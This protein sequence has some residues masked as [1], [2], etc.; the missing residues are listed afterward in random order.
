MNNFSSPK[1]ASVFNYL[2]GCDALLSSLQGRYS[3][4]GKTAIRLCRWKSGFLWH[5]RYNIGDASIIA[6][7]PSF[8]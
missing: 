5:F 6:S 3:R 7:P 4:T 2:H 1:R 8:W